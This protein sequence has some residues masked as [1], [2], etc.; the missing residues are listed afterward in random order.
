[1]KTL[2]LPVL[3]F[4][5]VLARGQAPV[6]VQGTLA[7]SVSGQPL[8]NA[9]LTLRNNTDS[10]WTTYSL[11]D[12]KG[13]FL[14]RNIRQ[15]WYTLRITCRGYTARQLQLFLEDEKKDVQAGKILLAAEYITLAEAVVTAA[16]PVSVK[17]DTTSYR[18]EAFATRAGATLEEGLKRMPGIEVQPD[19]RVRARGEIVQKIY[20]DGREFFSND[21]S[22]ALKN[23]AAGM[24]DRVDVFDE[25]SEQSRFT[26]TDDGQRT[27]VM[28]VRLRKDRNRGEFG[29]AELSAGTHQRYDSRFLLNHFSDAQRVSVTGSAG[30][31]NK[32]SLQ[33]GNNAGG[34]ASAAFSNGGAVTGGAATAGSGGISAAASGG[35]SYSGHWGRRVEISAGYMYSRNEHELSRLGTKKYFFAPDSITS[36]QYGSDARQTTGSHRLHARLQYTIDSFQSVLYTA[37]LFMQGTAQF[38]EDSSSTMAGDTVPYL[39]TSVSNRRMDDRESSGFGGELLYRRRFRI[40]GRTLVVGWRNNYSG[41]AVVGNTMNR[42]HLYTPAGLA[43]ALPVTDQETRQ[44]FSSITNAVSLAYTHPLGNNQLLELNYVYTAFHNQSDIRVADLDPDTGRYDEFNHNLSNAFGHRQHSNRAGASLRVKKKLIQ[45]QLGTSLQATGSA[46]RSIRLQYG[47]DTLIRQRFLNFFPAAAVHISLRKNASLRFFYRGSNQA[48]SLSQLQDVTDNRDP[49][50]WRSGNPGLKQEFI[51]RLDLQYNSYHTRSAVFFSSALHL[52]A[53]SNKIVNSTDTVQSAILLTRPVNQPGNYNGSGSM[54]LTLPL[55]K[56]KGAQLH[57]SSLAYLSRETSLLFR[58]RN[59]VLLLALDQS[60]GLSWRSETV[61][62]AFRGN[63]VYQSLAYSSQPSGNTASFRTG[64]SAQLQYRL[65]DDFFGLTSFE[66]VSYSG[67]A[68]GFN[69]RIYLWN[70][71]LSRQLG[72]KKAAEI[73]FTA[74]DLL[75]QDR[76]I[77]R[78]SGDYYVEDSR[79]QVVPRFFLLSFRYRF[80]RLSPG[81]SAGHREQQ[82]PPAKMQVFS[83]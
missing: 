42:V 66:Q 37:N 50:Q 23:L 15:G 9:S 59:A 63:M 35:I 26:R 62:L 11:S 20:V 56:W 19:G 71:A 69:Q 53:V 24:V 22:V 75:N 57:V 33:P 58:K 29:Q 80:Q 1:M 60:A 31:T 34:V 30:N 79:V 65:C 46:A 72:K 83:N 78:L 45:Y 77:S 82:V 27:R 54:T 13:G 38:A 3:L 74:Y 8:H 4:L 73:R 17:G 49:L 47:K 14:F 76:G 64:W 32:A 48:P 2:L 52:H 44:D 40:P 10:S 81:K 51:H 6:S 70:L 28:N 16:P 25:G 61:E 43:S 18:M 21:P 55:K 39:A 41:N 36:M 5:S 67:R 12:R 68:A 7:D